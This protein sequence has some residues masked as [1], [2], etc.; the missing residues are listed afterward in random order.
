[1]REEFDQS[2]VVEFLRRS[3]FVVD[4]LWFVKTEQAHG[5]EHAMDVDEAVWEVMAKVQARKA[6]ALLGIEQGDLSDLFRAFQ[7][8]LT[9]EGHEFDAEIADGEARLIIRRCPWFDIL[10]SSNRT[11]IAEVI[12]DRI[13]AR[14]YAGWTQEF[15]SG[16]DI[17]FEHRLCVENCDTC[18]I[19]FRAG[20]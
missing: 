10:R 14:E 2:S 1:M 20:Q 9:A 5:F 13:C 6:K 4:G 16:I 7:L 8:K 3:Y 12:A 11:H 19:V 18:S 17:E 15:K